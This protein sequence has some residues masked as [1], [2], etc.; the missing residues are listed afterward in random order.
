MQ[1]DFTQKQFDALKRLVALGNWLANAHREESARI[2]AFDELEQHI[3]AAAAAGGE[4][5]IARDA[6][7]GDFYAT[8]EADDDPVIGKLID[9]YD[10]D[11]FW[12]ELLHRLS[13]RDLERAYGHD[14]LHDEE[15]RATLEEPFHA[16]WDD[17]LAEYGI[18][19]L[20]VADEE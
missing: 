15:N 20:V 6:E 2:A 1:I 11:T 4:S 3:R 19:R 12:D 14:L 5:A 16:R 8:W 10:N 13:E 17:E 18:G 9:E 7:T